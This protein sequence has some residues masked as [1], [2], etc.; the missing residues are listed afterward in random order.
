MAAESSVFVRVAASA[1][2]CA[3]A[4]EPVMCHFFQVMDYGYPQF[5]EAQILQ[6][7]IK[8]D[9]YRMEVGWPAQQQQQ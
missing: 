1:N 5:T 3:V 7:F 8:T 9:S 4:T 2:P 6:E